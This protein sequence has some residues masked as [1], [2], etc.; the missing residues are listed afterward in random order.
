MTSERWRVGRRLVTAACNDPRVHLPGWK[1][2]AALL[3]TAGVLHLVRPQPFAT[4]VPRWL[5]DPAP[6]VL[7]S[8][9]AEIACAVGLASPKLRRPTALA[10]AGLLVAVFPANIQMAVA[11]MC[12]QEA[13]TAYRALTIARLPLQVPLVLWAWRLRRPV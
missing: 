9:L 6:W 2:L 1:P 11:A 8:G 12:S 5:G 10:T 3:G 13:S 4:I 7:V